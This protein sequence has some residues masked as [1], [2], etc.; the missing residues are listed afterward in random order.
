MYTH[1]RKVVSQFV[2]DFTKEELDLI[3]KNFY[4]KKLGKNEHLLQVGDV[5]K[6]VFFINKGIMR[7]YVPVVNKGQITNY[8]AEESMFNTSAVS[9]FHN[10]PHTKLYKQLNPAKVLLF[11]LKIYKSC[12]TVFTIGNDWVGYFYKPF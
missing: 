11:N 8:F 6:E 1:I 2:S 10:N 5:A 7:N 9:F 12:M 4:P 3:E